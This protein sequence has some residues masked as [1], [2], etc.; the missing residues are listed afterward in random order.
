MHGSVVRACVAMAY[1]EQFVDVQNTKKERV[2]KPAEKGGPP[3]A[4]SGLAQCSMKG[5]NVLVA[6][7]IPGD[8]EHELVPLIK[9]IDFG[10]GVEFN[11]NPDFDDNNVYKEY[12]GVAYNLDGVGFVGSSVSF[13]INTSVK[14]IGKRQKTVF[15]GSPSEME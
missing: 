7:V 15:Y 8:S 12:T 2:P 4:P 14:P 5:H 9:L 3:P 10:R 11:W 6:D 1:R 13:I